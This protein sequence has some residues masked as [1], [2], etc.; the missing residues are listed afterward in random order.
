M[1]GKEEWMEYC[2]DMEGK[3]KG[4]GQQHGRK[5]MLPEPVLI[6]WCGSEGTLDTYRRWA[7]RSI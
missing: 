6:V 3:G 7:H 2:R 5:P 4:D 1:A